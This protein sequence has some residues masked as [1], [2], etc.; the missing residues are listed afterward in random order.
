[1]NNVSKEM[2]HLHQPAKRE[3][4]KRFGHLWETLTEPEWLRQAWEESRSNKG[5]MTAGMD[6]MIAW[7]SPLSESNGCR[8][9]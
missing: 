5:S 6:A 1:M 3:P 4:G 2:K 8:S 9:D 7:T